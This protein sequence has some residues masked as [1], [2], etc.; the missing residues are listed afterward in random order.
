MNKR[1][2]LLAVLSFAAMDSFGQVVS[3]LFQVMSS[4]PLVI[5]PEVFR[6]M[7]NTIHDELEKTK[8]GLHL[9]I[10]YEEMATVRRKLLSLIDTIEI[11][12]GDRGS[13]K[14]RLKNGDSAETITL[15]DA[16]GLGKTP[17]DIFKEV[18]TR[19]AKWINATMDKLNIQPREKREALYAALI[20]ALQQAG[21]VRGLSTSGFEDSTQSRLAKL[22]AGLMFR[23]VKQFLFDKHPKLEAVF[24]SISTDKVL[25]T[26][27]GSFDAVVERSRQVA[28][29]ALDKAEHAAA[30]AIN[31]ISKH[32]V[33]GNIGVGATQG[34][35]A[36]VG[37][38]YYSLIMPTFQLGAYVN[39]QFNNGDSTMPTQSLFGGRASIAWDRVQ[40]EALYARLF[41]DEEF[42]N[43]ETGEFGVG[44]LWRANQ[45]FMLGLAYFNLHIGSIT[46]NHLLGLILRGTPP[47][48]PG[49]LFGVEV[50]DSQTHPIVQISFPI[51]PAK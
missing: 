2:I 27:M 21:T 49:L 12:K 33:A 45:D 38:V 35:G 16:N 18:E 39:G 41:G 14:F 37:G 25:D 50:E 24:N 32:L 44:V 51:N 34:A 29:E 13:M 20:I 22:V 46:K 1:M 15:V 6:E 47:E 48:S 11:S 3:P 30:E 5:R 4:N 40:V 8:P 31:D 42:S 19:V 17:N 26:L 36:F 23:E 43:L 28:V 7:Q 9:S 10:F